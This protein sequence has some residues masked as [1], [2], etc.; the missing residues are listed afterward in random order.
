MRDLPLHGGA[1]RGVEQRVLVGRHDE[2]RHQVLEHRSA[3]RQQD[4]PVADRHQQ[5]PQR[6]PA[7][8]RHLAL[9]DRD[10]AREA[11][12]GGEKVVEAAVA[13]TLVDVVA[14]GEQVARAVV[15]K[16]EIHP[17]EIRTLRR[18]RFD[19]RDALLRAHAGDAELPRHRV[20]EA[21]LG[22]GRCGGA[23]ALEV[24][25]QRRQ[26]PRERAQCRDRRQ[27]GK[28]CK[29]RLEIRVLQPRREARELVHCRL[30]LRRQCAHPYVRLVRRRGRWLARRGAEMRDDCREVRGNAGQPAGRR[31]GRRQSG[32]GGGIEIADKLGDDRRELRHRALRRAR[33]RYRRARQRPAAPEYGDRA[34]R[35][36]RRAASAGARPDCR[37]RPTRCSAAKAADSDC[38]SYQL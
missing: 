9:R 7:L 2:Q 22:I 24:R 14:D 37:C 4:R 3:P 34:T 23:Q 13:L 19:R 20:D 15:Q 5:P 30:A 6:E 26:Q 28:L 12:L 33:A 32:V 25:G 10:K 1:A 16:A 21:T 27:R 17:C 36:A 35:A 8:L 18:R 38:V 11:R 29:Q 31:R